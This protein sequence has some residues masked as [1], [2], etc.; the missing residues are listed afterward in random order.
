MSSMD[1]VGRRV[2]IVGMMLFLGWHRGRYGH[3]FRCGLPSTGFVRIKVD[4]CQPGVDGR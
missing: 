3:G 4:V 2:D 1:Q